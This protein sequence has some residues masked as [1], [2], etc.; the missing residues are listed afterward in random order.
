MNAEYEIRLA[1][2]EMAISGME[3]KRLRSKVIRMAL[4]LVYFVVLVTAAGWF[5][6]HVL[7]QRSMRP[8]V[9]EMVNLEGVE[10]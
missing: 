7:E 1:R 2:I 10:R 8:V 9:Q 6:R 5:V 3:R 4:F